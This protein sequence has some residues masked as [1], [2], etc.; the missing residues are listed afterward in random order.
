MLY[1]VIIYIYI[2]RFSGAGGYRGESGAGGYRGGPGAGGGRADGKGFILGKDRLA[3][4]AIRRLSLT[5]KE[6]EKKVFL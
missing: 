4:G 1:I 3:T 2:Y 5:E 6:E